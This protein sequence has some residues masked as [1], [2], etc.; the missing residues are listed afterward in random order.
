MILNLL[1]LAALVFLSYLFFT[2]FLKSINSR[3]WL[4]RIL[5]GLIT[6]ILM[7]VFTGA[8]LVGLFGMWRLDVPRSRV[9]PD[10]KVQSTP[11]LVSRGQAVAQSCIPCHSLDGGPV[12]NGGTANYGPTLQGYSLGAVY[13][14]NL[15]PGGDLKRWTDGEIIRA[16]REGVD[17]DGVPLM[18]PA[19]S[20]RDM[21]DA[22]ATACSLP[23]FAASRSCATTNRVEI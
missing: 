19:A 10:I 5:G 3:S 7:L 11:E 2:L 15:T 9:A 13:A 23:I 8:L 18:H 1:G 12:L 16:V 22:D 17:K 4:V 20:Y 21:S 6:G 14:S